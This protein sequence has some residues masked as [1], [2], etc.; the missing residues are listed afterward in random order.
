MPHLRSAGVDGIE[1]LDTIHAVPIFAWANRPMQ[2]LGEPVATHG[3]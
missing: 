2:T 3:D 1:I